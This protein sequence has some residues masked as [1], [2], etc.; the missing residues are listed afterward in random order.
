MRNFPRVIHRIILALRQRISHCASVAPDYTAVQ[1]ERGMKTESSTLQGVMTNRPEI[2]PFRRLAC[3][4]CGTEFECNPGGAC[5]C[6]DESF[7][8]PM[9]VEGEDC[10][11]RECLR[12][13][14]EQS[15]PTVK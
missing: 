4:R 3:S 9:P 11:C 7:R 14:A 2:T 5:W 8:L 13:A 1:D 10:L 15:P 12:K 6:A